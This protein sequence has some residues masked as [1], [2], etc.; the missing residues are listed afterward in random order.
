MRRF[1]LD[2]RSALTMPGVPVI[3][4]W[5]GLMSGIDAHEGLLFD[6]LTALLAIAYT[7]TVLAIVLALMHRIPWV[8]RRMDR[9]GWGGR[10]Q[11][12]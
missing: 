6:M 11:P 1:L 4:L 5:A 10:S 9:R 2:C 8:G 12:G 3:P 7:T